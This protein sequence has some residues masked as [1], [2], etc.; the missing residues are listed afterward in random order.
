VH[1]R[2]VVDRGE[3]AL[4]AR[5]QA[6]E[7]DGGRPLR[8]GVTGHRSFDRPLDVAE[9]VA[10]TVAE[11]A[12]RDDVTCLEV[13]SSLAEGADRL[14]AHHVLDE[15]DASLVAVLPLDADD[16]AADFE[17][18]KSTDEFAALLSGASEVIVTGPDESGSRESA[19]ERAGHVVT[20][21]ADVLIAVWDGEPARGRG[22]TT[23]IIDRARSLDRE[24]V[25]IPVT[26][27]SAR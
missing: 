20:D 12:G 23:E 24:V 14:V 22:G 1:S 25:V 17:T 15:P 10:A 26:R 13:W 9:R 6:D 7:G 8:V 3:Q 16:Y 27:P 11:L 4:S 19:Y 5:A 18:A 2:T 21:S